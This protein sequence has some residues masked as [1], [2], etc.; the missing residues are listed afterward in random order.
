MITSNDFSNIGFWILTTD[1]FADRMRLQTP[2]ATYCND[3]NN[4]S[5]DNNNI[6][7]DDIELVKYL[8]RRPQR[9]HYMGF[10]VLFFSPVERERATYI[11][12]LGTSLSRRVTI[13][14]L[15]RLSLWRL[16]GRWSTQRIP[17]CIGKWAYFP[18]TNTRPSWIGMCSKIGPGEHVLFMFARPTYYVESTIHRGRRC[19]AIVAYSLPCRLA[20]TSW[21]DSK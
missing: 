16:G 5:Q 2:P 9:P 4:V 17:P 15:A 6:C 11:A 8:R 14:S 21:W 7:R 10:K 3:V 1:S 13:R 20:S 18:D 19:I 12:W